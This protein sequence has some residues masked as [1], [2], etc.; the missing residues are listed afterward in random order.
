MPTLI[1]MR[2]KATWEVR[3]DTRHLHGLACALFEDDS[4]EHLRHDKPFA[5]WPL[6]P[7]AAQGEWTWRAAWLPDA[8]LPL[9]TATADSLRLGHV[10]C[11]VVERTQR[12]TTHAVLASGPS[13]AAATI[14]FGSPTFF[15]QNGSDIV[16]PDPKLI[17]GS[18]RR[19]WNASLPDG[20][21]LAVSDEEWK[22]THRLITL[23]GFDLRTERRDTGHGRDRAGF[24]G[25]ARLSIAKTAPATSRKIFS[26]LARFAGY[27][28][29][30]AQV[31]H[32][33]GATAVREAEEL[34]R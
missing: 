29:T 28:G 32:G 24:I 8:D 9:S 2:L 19:R 18:W 6:Q 11:A 26:T 30:G 25:T 10:S 17:V 33:F 7:D 34:R 4:S 13:L 5:V 1:E 12:R 27:S 20:D 22:A 23:T 21:R 15:S 14:T 3:P 31:T 16:I